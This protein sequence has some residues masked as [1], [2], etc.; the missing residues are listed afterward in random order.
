MDKP[1]APGNR[2]LTLST[3]ELEQYQQRL[4]KLEGAVDVET[5]LN[6]TIHQN[7]LSILDWLPTGFVDLLFIDPP[8]NLTKTFGA[9]EF[10]ERSLSAY[11]VWLESWLPQLL[12]TL[13]T[14]TLPPP[15]IWSPRNTSPSATALRGNGRKAE[16]PVPI[17]RTAQNKFGFVL[18]PIATPLILMPSNSNAGF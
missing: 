14:G 7:L 11:Q 1:R 5:I 15:F 6:Q 8:Y 16:V 9:T 10:K 12:R 2:T 4:L 17:G 13:K 18:R 3:E